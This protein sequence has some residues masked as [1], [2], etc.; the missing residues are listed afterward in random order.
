MLPYLSNLYYFFYTNKK[1]FKQFEI[2]TALPLSRIETLSVPQLYFGS[3]S[4]HETTSITSLT[5]SRCYLHQLYQLFKYAPMIKY[6][7]TKCLVSSDSQKNELYL[8]NVYAICLRRLIVES[9]DL[10]FEELEIFLKLM[11]NLINLT[12]SNYK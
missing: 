2:L 8:N 3:A 11:P 1:I 12:I 5:V 7:K 10:E 4:I 6:L 9:C